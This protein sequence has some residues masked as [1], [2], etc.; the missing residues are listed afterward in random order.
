[1]AAQHRKSQRRIV[2]EGTFSA[3]GRVKGTAMK[4]F[5]KGMCIRSED[6]ER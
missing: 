5:V 3:N 6:E 1:M 4:N 2:K